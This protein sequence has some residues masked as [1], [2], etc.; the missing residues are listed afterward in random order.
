MQYDLLELRDAHAKLRGTNEKL[1]R[2]KEKSEKDKEEYRSMVIKLFYN[3]L[4]MLLMNLTYFYRRYAKR[5]PVY[6]SKFKIFFF[7]FLF[8][9]FF[10]LLKH[11]SKIALNFGPF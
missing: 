10:F 9:L 8:F 3:L 4:I 1:R 7:F 11:L 2:E 5:A 6:K